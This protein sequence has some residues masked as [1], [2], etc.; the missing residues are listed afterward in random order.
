MV[1]QS[2]Y[3]N[4]AFISSSILS[5]ESSSLSKRSRRNG[6]LGR[7]KL[8]SRPS[9]SPSSSDTHGRFMVCQ[10]LYTNV[11][12]ISSSILSQERPKDCLCEILSGTMFAPLH[13]SQSVADGMAAL[14]GQSSGVGLPGHL[15]A[16]IIVV[17]LH[18]S[19]RYTLVLYREGAKL[20][21]KLALSI[22]RLNMIQLK[23]VL[24]VCASSSL[25]KRSRRNGGLGRAKLSW[26]L[27]TLVSDIHLFFI[28]RA[29]NWH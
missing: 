1:C 16:T 13:P 27:Y 2:L 20:A 9:R 29:R 21:L 4:V 19:F 6:G 15:P 28:E 8:R 12:F 22:A 10:S 7:A 3:T 5:Q 17:S 26:S 24:H 18:T 25:S 11:A 14:V 23:M